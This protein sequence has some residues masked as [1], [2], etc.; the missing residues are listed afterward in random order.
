MA[1]ADNTVSPS[2]GIHHFFKG[3]ELIQVPGIRKFVVLPLLINLVLFALAF[4]WL[5]TQLQTWFSALDQWLPSW[6]GWIDVILWPLAIISIVIVFSFIFAAVANWI[7]APFNGMLAEKVEQY[8]VGEPLTDNG[9][10]DM[11]SDLPRLLAREWKKLVYYLPRAAIFLC[12]FLVPVVGQTVAP[13][14]WFLF[15]AWMMAIQYLDYA[16]DNHKVPFS[17]MRQALAANKGQ[18][19]SFGIM[20]MLFTMLPIIN[21]IVMPVAICGATSLWVSRYRSTLR[22]R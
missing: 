9:W 22:T 16:F 17:T 13:L 2:S 12:L 21:L 5:L 11:F 18:S 19:Y 6:L 1:I 3:F 8:L 15:S 20:A 14:I 7:A 10:L 4:G